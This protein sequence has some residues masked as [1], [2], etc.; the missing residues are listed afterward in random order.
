MR[1]PLK[2]RAVAYGIGTDRPIRAQVTATGTWQVTQTQ[3]HTMGAKVRAVSRRSPAQQSFDDLRPS[4]LHL[5]EKKPRKNLKRSRAKGA[6]RVERKH[7]PNVYFS[8]REA[9][10]HLPSRPKHLQPAPTVTRARPGGGPLPHSPG[11]PRPGQPLATYL[12][13]RAARYAGISPVLARLNPLFRS[14]N[15]Y[16]TLRISS[17]HLRQTLR[18]GPEHL[19]NT[20]QKV[21]RSTLMLPRAA[22]PAPPVKNANG[23][24][25]R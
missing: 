25:G 19:P 21:L 13:P 15:P 7:L 4:V 23:A 20:P 2:I 8:L 24:S 17:K 6:S 16:Q 1:S 12:G 14:K 9:S 5:S 11:T 10:K 3:G 22:R 18:F